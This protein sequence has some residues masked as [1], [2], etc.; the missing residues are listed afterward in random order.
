MRWLPIR[1]GVLSLGPSVVMA[2]VLPAQGVQIGPLVGVYYAALN[3]IEQSDG[4]SAK[5]A[6]SVALGARF[7]AATQNKISFDGTITYVPS[8]VTATNGASGGSARLLLLSAR[9]LMAFGAAESRT[10]FYLAGG[11]AI[12]IRNGDFYADFQGTTDV[13]GNVAAGVRIALGRMVGRVEVE[14]YLYAVDL[15]G[16]GGL[17]TGSELQADMVASA[18]FAIPLG[19]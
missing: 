3:V 2:G 16:A 5:Q 19:P 11:P 8:D 10:R 14:S 12:I 15:Q 18:T 4:T 17:S 7:S 1:A 6:T 13:G 9:G